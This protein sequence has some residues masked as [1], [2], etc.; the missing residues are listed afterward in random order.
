MEYYLEPVHPFDLHREH[1]P[2]LLPGHVH[3]P[4]RVQEGQAAIGLGIAVIVVLTITV[5]VNN[6]IY[7]TCS[8]TA[9]WPGPGLPDVDL[10]F[11]GLA[12]LHRRD[13][14]AGADPG[15]VPRQVRA[16]AVQ[17]ARRIPAPDHRELR[18][19]RSLAVHGRTRLQLRRERGVWRR[20]RR[21]LGAGHRR[22]RGD[23]REAQVLAMCPTA[24]RDSA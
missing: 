1:G 6:L 21:R 19:P 20:C 9:R 13:R 18:D 23:T 14:G 22:P 5:P 7:N 4:R 12:V 24:C 15:D 10:S 8:P 2:G 3:F 11:L 17:R 16:G